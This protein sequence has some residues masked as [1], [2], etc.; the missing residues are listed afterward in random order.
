VKAEGMQWALR[1]AGM[2]AVSALACPWE[3]RCRLARSSARAL[4]PSRP[5]RPERIPAGWG[6]GQQERGKKAWGYK[7]VCQAAG[8][9]C[10]NNVSDHGEC[11]KLWR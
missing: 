5:N 6:E 8:G 2:G 10:G 3:A 1:R 4:A 9:A 7:R 11:A